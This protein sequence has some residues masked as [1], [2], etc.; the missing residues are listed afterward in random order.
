[1]DSIKI[2][3]QLKKLATDNEKRSKSARLN[4]LLDDIENALKN[5][6]SRQSVI[7][8]LAEN[9]FEISMK[10]F[11]STLARLRRK[12][13]DSAIKNNQVITVPISSSETKQTSNF[14]H[15]KN[16]DVALSAL[17]L[18]SVEDTPIKKHLSM[19]EK[20]ALKMADLGIDMENTNPLLKKRLQ[21]LKDKEDK[22]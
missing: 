1:M 12:R 7:E 11:E 8:L 18:S 4:D 16:I 2:S 5:G 19:R 15:E 17:P 20:T 14:S 21:Q 13:K 6:I 3:E 10:S 9:G 22:K